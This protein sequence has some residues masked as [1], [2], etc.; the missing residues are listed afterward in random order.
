M[1]E[2]T[3]Q[4]LGGHYSNL[5]ISIEDRIFLIRDQ[6]VM[7]DRDLA[8]LYQVETKV[9]NQAARRN[10]E[11]FPDDFRFQLTNEEKI[12]LVTNCDRFSS[13]KHS[14]VNPHAFTEHGVLMLANVLK[15][16][17][18]T[19]MSIKLIKTFILIR[20]ALSTN[21]ALKLEIAEIRQ[22]VNKIAKKQE[23]Q[24]KNIDLLFEYI[25]RLQEKA[26]EPKPERK[27]IGYKDKW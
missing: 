8:E 25:D 1:T 10:I 20:K 4:N 14:T 6:Q 9:L 27:R 22:S 13:L 16:N 3:V 5:S 17:I 21:I 23:G 2:N 11:K 24:D 7:I 26:E 15:S 12:E 19:A 18:A